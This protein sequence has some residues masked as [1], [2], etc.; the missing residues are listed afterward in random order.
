MSVQV[1]LANESHPK[2]ANIMEEL[3]LNKS[4]QTTS[5]VDKLIKSKKPRGKKKVIKTNCDINVK[6]KQVVKKINYSKS[7]K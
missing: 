3:K 6:N 1:K 4:N 7:Q 2:P 5:D